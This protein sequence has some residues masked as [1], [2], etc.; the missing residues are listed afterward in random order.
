M[1][2]AANIVINDGAGTPV[3]YT[4]TPIQK[5]EK[6]VVWFEQV[7]PAPNNPLGAFRLSYKQVRGNP[8]AS[9]QLTGVGKA[10]WCIWMPYLETLGT[11]DSGI[12]PPPTISHRQVARLELDLPERGTKNQRRDMR[13]FLGNLTQNSLFIATVDDLQTIY[14]V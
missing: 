8:Q 6:G 14:G 9:S 1:P 11:S 4:F 5:D 2:T 12:T 3:A 13:A 7:T 10:V